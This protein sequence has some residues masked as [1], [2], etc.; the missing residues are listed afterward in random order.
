MVMTCWWDYADTTTR[1]VT[2]P[3]H[4]R[5]FAGGSSSPGGNRQGEITG[6][7]R[8]ARGVIG[9]VQVMD[10]LRWWRLVWPVAV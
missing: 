6:S 8:R 1:L 4:R 7:P 9:T 10:G 3:Y 5:P 2:E